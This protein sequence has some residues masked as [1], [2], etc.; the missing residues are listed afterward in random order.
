[1]N[2]ALRSIGPAR[3]GEAE[4]K[5]NGSPAHPGVGV[6]LENSSNRA[7]TVLPG[8]STLVPW[9]FRTI[10]R[11]ALLVPPAASLVL[12]VVDYFEYFRAVPL[13][14][15]DFLVAFL[16]FAIPAG[17]LFG[18]IPALVAGSL[19]SA[20]LTANPSLLLRRPFGRACVAAICGGSVSWAWFV[21]WLG[22]D[23]S[24]YAL[25][26]AL[27]TAALTLGSPSSSEAARKRCD[28]RVGPGPRTHRA[29]PPPMTT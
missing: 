19:Y 15:P 27:V 20:A 7:L 23:S 29:E 21:A 17:Y 12:L 11:I 28:R 5:A 25:T 2:S 10:A 22:I 24:I 16:L 13:N 26:R 1:M 14:L 9:Q 18:V 6:V 4:S 8:R 3:E